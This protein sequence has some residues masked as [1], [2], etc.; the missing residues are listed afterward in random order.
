VLFAPEEEQRQKAEQVERI[1]SRRHVSLGAQAIVKAHDT[2]DE[3][4]Y[5]ASKFIDLA[6]ETLRRK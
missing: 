2:F 3:S 5:H 4:M 1:S 6:R